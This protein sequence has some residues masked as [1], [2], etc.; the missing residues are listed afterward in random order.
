M[1]GIAYPLHVSCYTISTLLAVGAGLDPVAGACLFHPSSGSAALR[2]CRGPAALSTVLSS[3]LVCLQVS[4]CSAH[5]APLVSRPPAGDGSQGASTQTAVWVASATSMAHM[6]PRAAVLSTDAE[7]VRY[8]HRLPVDFLP[9]QREGSRLM[10]NRD[11]LAM[12]QPDR[13]A[14]LF[15][16]TPPGRLCLEK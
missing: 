15:R 2:L 7:L 8:A 16:K 13:A 14:L 11:T 9:H 5:A 1:V 12:P 6:S 4:P 10:E 3:L